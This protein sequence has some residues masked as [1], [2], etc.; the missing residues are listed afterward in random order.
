MPYQNAPYIGCSVIQIYWEVDDSGHA[1]DDFREWMQ[2]ALLQL[3]HLALGQQLYAAL[4]MAGHPVLIRRV[5][6]GRPTNSCV[7]GPITKFV[8][9]RRALL[10][11]S[12]DGVA[13][14]LAHSLAEAAGAGIP[15]TRL[16]QL[17]SQRLSAVTNQTMNNISGGSAAVP[18]AE[19]VRVY[20]ILYRMAN[21]DGTAI[22]EAEARPGGHGTY[23]LS[24]KLIRVLRP[25]LRPGTGAGSAIFFDP[26]NRLSCGND[27]APADRP[28]LIG[29][30]HELCHAWRNSSGMRLF[31][32]AMACHL[33]DDEVMTTGI[34]PY[35]YE[36]FSE[37]LFRSVYPGH[38]D[39]RERYR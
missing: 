37:N 35:L 6:G 8:A 12:V 15:L 20:D 1:T 7:C 19:Y 14:E 10:G 4:L 32:D 38:L 21:R 31:D 9:L 26:D 5:G 23:S 22:A 17:V 25:W 27:G 3:A 36:Q 11:Q 28:P 18:A 30:A 16:A 33:P 29:L 2:N 13:N 24:D 39:M 34:P